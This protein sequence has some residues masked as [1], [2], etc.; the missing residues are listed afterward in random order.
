DHGAGEQTHQGAESQPRLPPG[1][2]LGRQANS[3]GDHHSALKARP[4]RSRAATS[5]G[6]TAT[7]LAT[8]TV[9]GRSRSNTR[10]GTSGAGTMPR[11]RAKTIHAH[12]P[13]ATPSGTPIA[14]A[15]TASVV[16]CHATAVRT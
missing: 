14:M 9:P 12:R 5:P 2:K 16:A 7:R 13:A 3:N 6:I 4:G 15:A 11:P 8:T 1:P 10:M